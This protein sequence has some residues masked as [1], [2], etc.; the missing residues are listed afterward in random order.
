LT[1]II[2]NYIYIGSLTTWVV[3]SGRHVLRVGALLV[4]R[5]GLLLIFGS[6]VFL[7]STCAYLGGLE[8]PPHD[9]LRQTAED[10]V[11]PYIK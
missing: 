11:G 1:T 4:T 9:T 7:F 8:Y 10:Y 5:F 2:P 6:F 3:A